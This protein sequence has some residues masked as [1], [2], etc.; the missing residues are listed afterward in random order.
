MTETQ[1]L[2]QDFVQYL[3][4]PII[5][6]RDLKTDQTAFQ[7]PAIENLLRF[8]VENRD[9]LDELL[10]NIATALSSESDVYKKGLACL[11]SGTLI[12]F[13]GNPKIIVETIVQ[14]LENHLTA[15][16][17]FLTHAKQE[18]LATDKLTLKDIELLFAC[19][20]D[21]V[22]SWITAPYVVLAAMTSI[23]RVKEARIQ[24][25]QNSSFITQVVHLEDD[26]DNLYYLKQVIYSVDDF[27][28]I[29]LHPESKTGLRLR[30][31]M[32]QNNFHFFTLL[33][34][35]Y[36]NQF[37]SLADF[38]HLKRNEKA[39]QLAKGVNIS[40]LDEQ[41]H[42]HA[43]FGFYDYGSL[44]EKG[45]LLQAVPPANWLFGE[46]TLYH[47][48]KLNGVPIVL[49]GKNSLGGR[50]WD[51]TFCTPV[52]EALKPKLEVLEV[53]SVEQIEEQIKQIQFHIA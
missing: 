31:E 16:E 15:V 13:G 51:I 7:Q 26:I 42:D 36:V 1:R 3:H 46:G 38:A 35:Q 24:L 48:P 43:L 27:E 6:S 20:A 37:G 17:S 9:K 30:A 21:A 49:L 11:I 45:N 12:E 19:D 2:I 50:S 53:L 44:D 34:D 10:A 41:I 25:R 52:H 4:T 47:V 18:R 29:A 28:L 39:I 33:Q 14:Q 40:E 22:K 5:S 8:A 23:C 32:I